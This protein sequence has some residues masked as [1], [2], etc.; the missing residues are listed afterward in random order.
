MKLFLLTMLFSSLVDASMLDLVGPWSNH[1]HDPRRLDDFDSIVRQTY[2]SETGDE[3]TGSST[4]CVQVNTD[5]SSALDSDNSLQ[6]LQDIGDFLTYEHRAQA[7]L[8]CDPGQRWIFSFTILEDRIVE[9]CAM[10]SVD[11]RSVLPGYEETLTSAP[12]ETPF[13]NSFLQPIEEAQCSL[14]EIFFSSGNEN[15]VQSNCFCP[16]NLIGAPT[17]GA[18]EASLLSGM[19]RHLNDYRLSLDNFAPSSEAPSSAPSSGAPSLV[20]F[21]GAPSSG[22]PSSGAPSSGAPSLVPFSGAPSSGAPSSGAPSSGAPSSGAPS[23]VPFSG[24]PSSGAPSSG[25]PSSGAPSLVPFSGAPSSGAS[26]LDGVVSFQALLELEPVNCTNLEFQVIT[27][28]IILYIN[29]DP[30]TLTTAQRTGIEQLVLNTINGYNAGECEPTFTRAISAKIVLDTDRRHRYLLLDNAHAVRL[31][32]DITSSSSDE[33]VPIQGFRRL[34]IVLASQDF[35]K[36]P[37]SLE[38]KLLTL[39]NG[40]GAITCYCPVH[41]GAI[42]SRITLTLL[43]DIVNQEINDVIGDNTTEIQV[44]GGT[45]IND[46]SCTDAITEEEIET[47]IQITLT[48]PFSELTENETNSIQN[49]CLERYNNIAVTDCGPDT[50]FA[51]ECQLLSGHDVNTTTTGLGQSSSAYLFLKGNTAYPET[52][53]FQ[54][55]RRHLKEQ[56]GGSKRD[57]LEQDFKHRHLQAVSFDVYTQALIDN[58]AA[59][60]DAQEVKEVGCTGGVIFLYVLTLSFET[61]P[62]S[63]SAGEVSEFEQVFI[64]QS[65]ELSVRF[66][67]PENYVLFS[68]EL[69]LSTSRH[70]ETNLDLD[71][72]LLNRFTTNIS[73][74][75]AQH[76]GADEDTPLFEESVKRQLQSVQGSMTGRLVSP[77]IVKV[78]L[79]QGVSQSNIKG[80]P[81]RFLQQ[82]GDLVDAPCFCEISRAPNGNAVSQ[83]QVTVADVNLELATTPGQISTGPV[84]QCCCEQPGGGIHDSSKSTKSKEPDA[85]GSVQCEGAQVIPFGEGPCQCEFENRRLGK[86]PNK[87]KKKSKKSRKDDEPEEICKVRSDVFSCS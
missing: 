34:S 59:I 73:I 13:Y 26:S 22:A 37:P 15:C 14:E 85:S 61:D 19:N 79:R 27:I 77:S 75:A 41:R 87:G 71:R 69:D 3:Y 51:T 21:S 42:G 30:E 78:S 60:Q 32:V 7:A 2:C 5:G 31:Y 16:P 39:D 20:P 50:V 47:T 68:A 28:E 62:T 67:D 83:T 35:V 56:Q 81:N 72:E 46:A 53:F 9:G 70:L 29:I 44:T 12:N 76:N 49:D 80:V 36:P 86:S 52:T 82:L 17:V 64:A 24:A 74:L 1:N 6:A 65:N 66:C 55:S 10:F 58:N 63:W 25:A 48:K 54:N 33:P 43:V 57:E 18:T 45:V 38:R 23:L 4:V 84:N 8:S 11:F 40:E